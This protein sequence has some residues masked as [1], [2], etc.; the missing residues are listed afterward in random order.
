MRRLF[1][2]AFVLVVLA[3]TVASG[4]QVH[5]LLVS[6]TADRKIGKECKATVQNIRSSLSYLIPH[7]R[8]FLTIR[9]SHNDQYNADSLLADIRRV[10]VAQN[11]TFV[12]FYDG[13][14]ARARGHHYLHMPDGGKLWSADLQKAVK[15]KAC[16]LGVILTGSCNVPA[17]RGP[18]FAP[19][20][21]EEW[22]VQRDGMAPVMK[23]LFINHSGLMHMNGAWPGQFGFT[24]AKLG[25]WLFLEFFSYCKLCPTGRP[26]WR[27][28]D[29][30]MDRRLGKR[31]QLAF[32]GRYEEPETGYTQTSLKTISW[33]LPKNIEHPTS[34]FGV[35]GDDSST[36]TGVK[37]RR[38]DRNGPAGGKLRNGDIIVSINGEEVK[39]AV[40]FFDLVRSSSR[41]MKFKYS[42]R[43][44]NH[45]GEATLRW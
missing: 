26:T 14:G 29:R 25:N 34:R 5:V 17:V 33:S 23:E 37:V 7:N 12:F 1:A 9:V 27:C 20:A 10:Q 11:D 40:A 3:N 38:V 13:H 4:Q 16:R 18:M 36:R 41:I 42:R 28:I 22:N 45:F 15:R 43:G 31:F 19:K 2:I 6:D 39:D 24:H 35:V 44:T 32:N 8:Y 21:A 30:M